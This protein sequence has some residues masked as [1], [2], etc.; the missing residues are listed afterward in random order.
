MVVEWAKVELTLNR[1]IY[2][3]FAMLDLSKMLM[4]DFDYKYIK[5]KYPES[6]LLFTYTDSITYKIQPNNLYK[7][8]FADKHLFDFSEYK[9]E[10]LFYN[11][12]NKKVIS[13]IKDELNG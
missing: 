12:E 6:T 8:F 1:P 5:R 9:K 2:V 7:D 13:K 4:Y 10:S 11:G 3:E